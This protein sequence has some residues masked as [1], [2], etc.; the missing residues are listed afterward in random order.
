MLT[1]LVPALMIAQVAAQS[2]GFVTTLG[3]DTVQIEQFTRAGNEMSGTV[4]QRTPAMR[5]I[6]WSMTLDAGR[7]VRYVATATNVAGAPVLDGVSGSMTFIGDSIVRDAYQSGQPVT[8]RIAAIAGTYPGPGLPYIG[9][10]NLMYE[11]A[12]QSARARAAGGDTSIM[13][14]T[15]IG[16]QQ[17]AGRT[18]AWLIGPDSAEL[19][20][21]GQ[22]RSGYKFD[23]NG[24][25]LRADW[26]STTYRYVIRRVASVD[27]E[28]IA[29]AWAASEREGKG[30][31]AL[32]PR[33]SSIG[34]VDGA[35]VTF[36]Y[37]RPSKRGRVVWGDVVPY[38]K[39]WRLGADMATHF[40]AEAD[41]D[42]GG[43]T[44]PAGRY[45]LWMIAS[46]TD[47]QLVVSRAVNVF[48]T[49]YNPSKDLA[50]IPLVRRAGATIAER[51]TLSVNDGN[52]AIAWDDVVWT[53]PVRK[54]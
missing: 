4:V 30:F 23:A 35:R 44:I 31:G 41:L 54:K 53:V 13:L 10:S 22:A 32:S 45:T 49:Q 52:L 5:T 40:T 21:F 9:V 51:L 43:T 11:G 16:A 39:V 27:L 14:L 6:K 24:M 2:G 34:A 20:Y 26:R 33:D 15:M 47:P 48:G 12:F 29:G 38:D 17:R 7:P 28:R 18:R 50:R 25:L 19:D 46:A 37:S 3:A 8:A 42:I 1:V 36:D